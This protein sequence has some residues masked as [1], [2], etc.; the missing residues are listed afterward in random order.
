MTQSMYN[1][2]RIDGENYSDKNYKITNYPLGNCI[3]IIRIIY[4]GVTSYKIGRTSD[5]NT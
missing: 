1:R 3:Y 2:R 4:N 5:L